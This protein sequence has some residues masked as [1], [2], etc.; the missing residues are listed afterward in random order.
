MYKALMRW[1]NGA[2]ARRSGTL[3][4][5]AALAQGAV[6]VEDPAN[7][8]PPEWDNDRHH[9]IPE[10]QPSQGQAPPTG[11]PAEGKIRKRRRR[12]NEG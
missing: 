11:A 6:I 7:R 12:I 3:F 4:I 9:V 8:I 1:P 10:E 5:Q 2:T